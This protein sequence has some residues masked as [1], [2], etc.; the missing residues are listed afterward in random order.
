M[1]PALAS[2]DYVLTVAGSGIPRRGHVIVIGHP[3]SPGFDLIKRVVALPHEHVTIAGGRVLVEEQPLDE[4]W[5]RGPT[6]PEGSWAVGPDEV[7]LLGDNR[8]RSL[9]DGRTLG[10]VSL[11]SGWWRV[12]LRYWPV[13][14][15]GKV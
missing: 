9:A 1:E 10:P 12:R 4:P 13:R 11:R 3:G 14:R 8:T 5:A 2:G 7:F 15:I 6:A